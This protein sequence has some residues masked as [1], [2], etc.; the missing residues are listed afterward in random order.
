[1]EGEG[2]STSWI[3]WK[4]YRHLMTLKPGRFWGWVSKLLLAPRTTAHNFPD[5]SDKKN[6]CLWIFEMR[7]PISSSR[8]ELG[9]WLILSILWVHDPQTA[10]LRCPTLE[11][12]NFFLKFISS[13]GLK[14]TFHTKLPL[15]HFPIHPFIHPSKHLTIHF[16]TIHAVKIWMYTL[17]PS[18]QEKSTLVQRIIYNRAIL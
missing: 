10:F 9:L 7:F 16:L 1:M 2:C 11:V 14:F 18:Y 6:K 3:M 17:S 5:V 12:F 13:L 8:P 15:T 4:D